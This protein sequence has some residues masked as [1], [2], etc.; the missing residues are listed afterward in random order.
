MVIS[1]DQAVDKSP[2]DLKGTVDENLK[3]NEM[4]GNENLKG[5]VTEI[6]KKGTQ[7]MYWQNKNMLHIS[8]WL[9]KMASKNH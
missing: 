8:I 6:F 3:G 2:K 5:R 1:W 9:F 4:K 7:V